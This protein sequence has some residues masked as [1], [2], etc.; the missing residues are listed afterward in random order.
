MKL[1]K[2]L[3]AFVGV[4]ALMMGT[5][6]GLATSVN[7]L[8]DTD[9]VTGS[10]LISCPVAASVNITA[11]DD[12][13]TVTFDDIENIVEDRSTQTEEGAIKVTV[14][15]GCYLGSWQVNATATRFT[16]PD[17]T[18]RFGADHLSLEAEGVDYY[19]DG[20]DDPL[21]FDDVMEPDVSDAQFTCNNSTTPGG[22]C[23]EEILATNT[24]LLTFLLNLIFGPGSF[25][26]NPAPF[27]TVASYT[28]FLEDLP[29]LW[30][31]N[32]YSSTI[33]VELTTD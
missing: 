3:I 4:A 25:D 10:V 32:T 11:D 23:G 2:R 21:F 18:Q 13:E 6:A 33:T 24:N 17:T 30:G 27:T 20:V 29:F 16:S 7:A 12:G 8:E 1:M 19:F 9:T 31:S 22:P 14:D 15:M 5:M 26:A 28:G